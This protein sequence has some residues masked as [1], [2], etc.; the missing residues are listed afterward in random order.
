M[1][2][3]TT[4]YVSQYE[5]CN[6]AKQLRSELLAIAHD[7][8]PRHYS[9]LNASEEKPMKSRIWASTSGTT[10][11]AG[12]IYDFIDRLDERTGNQLAN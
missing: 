6:I 12:R 5:W 1:S 11:L 9:P 4:P 10:G 8:Y 7:A 3:S 2:Q